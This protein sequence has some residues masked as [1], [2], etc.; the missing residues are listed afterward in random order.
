MGVAAGVCACAFLPFAAGRFDP[1]AASVAD[2]ANAVGLVSLALVP[3]GLLWSVQEL[4]RSRAV[5]RG[6]AIGP[7]GRWLSVAALVLVAIVTATAVVTGFTTS[8]IVGLVLVAFAG[9]GLPP[10]AR[11]LRSERARD[12]AYRPTPVLLALLPLLVVATQVGLSDKAA[13]MSRNRVIESSS[14]LVADVEAYRAEH[15][16]YPE[17]LIALWPDYGS[18]TRGVDRYQ[19]ERIGD[20]YQLVFEQYRFHPL[21]TRELVVYNPRDE[22]LAVS[23]ASW[24]LE[25]PRLEGRQLEGWYEAHDAGAPHWRYFWFD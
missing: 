23:H 19:Y 10:W 12:A 14:E 20:A 24:R 15:G 5:R 1:V 17:S 22:H 8:L 18:S 21:G 9:L 2:V 25:D 11:A 7:I 4:S 6:R 13:E 3:L 16:R